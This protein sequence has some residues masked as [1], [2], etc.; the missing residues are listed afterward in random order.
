[1]LLA[2]SPS[3]ILHLTVLESRPRFEG[4]SLAAQIAEVM[5]K[6][7]KQA[8]SRLKISI[9]PDCAVGS[10]VRN[11]DV[12]V[13]G[14][15]RI[16]A[17]GD[18]SN[19]IGSLSVA[20]CAKYCTEKVKVVVLSEIDKVVAD[21]EEEGE[22]EV[23]HDSEVTDAWPREV[24]DGL[25]AGDIKIDV[26]G[27][28]FEW[29]PKELVDVYVTERGVLSREEIGQC[30]EEIRVLEKRIFG[31]DADSRENAKG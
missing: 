25:E 15:D 12:V 27:E 11:V 3:L 19:K 16:S 21:R 13:L 17:S 22:R 9:A 31:G 4:A 28:W 1:M 29:V 18:V 6:D 23:H 8:L 26:L 30:A 14:A 7:H 10:I 24:R 5:R 2:T 20:A